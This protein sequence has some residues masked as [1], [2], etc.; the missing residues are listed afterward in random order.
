MDVCGRDKSVMLKIKIKNMPAQ[1]AR[2][3]QREI[4]IYLSIRILIASFPSR[5]VSSI[6]GFRSTINIA[7]ERLTET[8]GIGLEIV[9]KSVPA[10]VASPAA[11]S[12][13][14]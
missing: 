4:I 8:K 14:Q 9:I 2:C 7:I 12:V 6:L 10:Q 1:V 11:H 3:A 13:K 5:I